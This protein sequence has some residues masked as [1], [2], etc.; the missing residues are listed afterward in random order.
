MTRVL[1]QNAL[2][3]REEE[4]QIHARSV[5][6]HDRGCAEHA[7]ERTGKGCCTTRIVRRLYC[8]LMSW[9]LRIE[10]VN[11]TS[12]LQFACHRPCPYVQEHAG[13]Q[14]SSDTDAEASQCTPLLTAIFGHNLIQV[15]FCT[16]P[17]LEGAAKRSAGAL[18]SCAS[19]CCRGLSRLH[20]HALHIIEL[21]I[22]C[23][24]GHVT[25]CLLASGHAC[26]CAKQWVFSHGTAGS[27]A[28][29][30]C[31]LGALAW[32]CASSLRCHDASSCDSCCSRLSWKSLM[33][34]NDDAI[35][36]YDLWSM[37]LKALPRNVTRKKH[38][39]GQSLPACAT[40][41][42]KACPCSR[43]RHCCVCAHNARYFIWLRCAPA[44]SRAC[45]A[46]DPVTLYPQ[47]LSIRP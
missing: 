30:S 36:M 25:T 13:H 23:Q 34:V 39:L 14:P 31:T 10:H 16:R 3:A 45:T 1:Q 24:S 40:V 18:R 12:T 22:Y 41:A 7:E 28:G 15:E 27:F 4:N 17:R 44:A 8:S 33:C 42:A 43:C 2:L 20:R 46:R 47:R 19:S 38:G 35:Y 6:M 21:L 32:L 5:C 37:C 11:I 29:C 9:A 26:S